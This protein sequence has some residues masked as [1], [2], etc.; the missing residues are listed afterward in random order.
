M[1]DFLTILQL[2]GSIFGMV[3][4]P[5][6]TMLHLKNAS[7]INAGVTQ[8]ISTASALLTAHQGGVQVGLAQVASGVSQV[9]NAISA[10][11]AP[12]ATKLV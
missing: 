9:A 5:I 10:A 1:N 3:G 11:S 4:V 2:F 12:I 7:A 8:S 6:L